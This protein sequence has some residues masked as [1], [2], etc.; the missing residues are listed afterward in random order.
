MRPILQSFGGWR[1]PPGIEI[2]GYVRAP[3][4]EEAAAV[5]LATG[6]GRRARES[7]GGNQTSYASALSQTRCDYPEVMP[8]NGQ[9]GCFDELARV[10]Q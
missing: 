8:E 4:G 5:G 3:P 6:G 10:K 7:H 1:F 2:P 9:G